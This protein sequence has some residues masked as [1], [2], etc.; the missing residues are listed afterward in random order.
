MKNASL[1]CLH[2]LCPFGF[3]KSEDLRKSSLNRQSKNQYEQPELKLN[4]SVP[5]GK[6][7]MS[8]SRLSNRQDSRR[9]LE[10]PLSRNEKEKTAITEKD[11]RIMQVIRSGKNYR[12]YLVKKEN[13]GRVFAMRL[14]GRKR[15]EKNSICDQVALEKDILENTKHPFIPK[16]EWYFENEK[17]IFFVMEFVEGGGSLKKILKQLSRFSEEITRFY[18]AEILLAL[19]YLHTELQVVYNYVRLRNFLLDPQGHIKI[20]DFSQAKKLHC[21][22]PDSPTKDTS[23]QTTKETNIQEEMNDFWGLGCLIYEML[24]GRKP[25]STTDAEGGTEEVS[26]TSHLS[27]PSS[28]SKNAKDLV[29]RLLNKDFGEKLGFADIDEIKKHPFFAPISWD[30]IM[31]KSI[32]P[33][34]VPSEYKDENKSG[35]DLEDDEP[36]DIIIKPHKK[37]SLAKIMES[38]SMVNSDDEFEA[39][40]FERTRLGSTFG[41]H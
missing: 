41:H 27:W 36:D 34:L 7:D 12:I 40:T 15:M 16:L 30:K 24:T 38:S 9:E 3:L 4:L 11:F 22:A 5:Q 8:I 19:E 37:A 17:K 13:D 33:P 18:S 23:S 25:F 2:S 26:P 32:Y 1:N 21:P 14:I 39:V 20:I 29:T 35:D 28:V 10:T 6:N 31:S